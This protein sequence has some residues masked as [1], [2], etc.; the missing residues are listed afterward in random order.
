MVRMESFAPLSAPL[1]ARVCLCFLCSSK[2]DCGESG[3]TTAETGA[4]ETEEEEEVVEWGGGG[5]K[6]TTAR[7]GG[8]DSGSEKNKDREMTERIHKWEPQEG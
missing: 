7:V 4:A 5:E 1:R 3:G 8:S 6:W 2:F